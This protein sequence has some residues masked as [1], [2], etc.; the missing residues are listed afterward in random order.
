MDA[1]SGSSDSAISSKMAVTAASSTYD[2]TYIDIECDP[3]VCNLQYAMRNER[4]RE[5][6]VSEP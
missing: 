2:D 6:N 1:M 4:V 5:R 3:I